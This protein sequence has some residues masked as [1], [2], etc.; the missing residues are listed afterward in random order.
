VQVEEGRIAGIGGKRG[1][2]TAAPLWFLSEH[3]LPSLAQVLGPPYELAAAFQSGL[4]AGIEI[5]ALEV[6][7]TRDLTRPE[8]VV[9]ENFPYLWR[10]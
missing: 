3:V 5:L 7:P 1:D 4:D 8:D 10:G 6:G 2:M 9:A